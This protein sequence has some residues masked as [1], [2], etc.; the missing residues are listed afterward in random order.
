M[1]ATALFIQGAG[2]MHQPDGSIHLARFLE[3]S[4]E[5]EYRVLA[6]EMPDA[7]E[8]PRYEPWRGAIEN[9]LAAIEGPVVVVGHSLGGSVALKMLSESPA[10]PAIRGL[11]LLSLPWWGPEGWDYAEY[12]P[13]EGFG[14]RLPDIPVF[15]YHSIDDPHV[16]IDHLQR[17]AAELPQATVR[18]I[19]GAEHSFV[20]GL[21]ELVTDIRGIQV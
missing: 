3:R 14:A 10:P 5:N 19:P 18:R 8:D 21:P 1:V 9:E 17:Y 12:A 15:V 16:P 20:Q 11:F 6:P 7:D 4:L 13:A 2:D